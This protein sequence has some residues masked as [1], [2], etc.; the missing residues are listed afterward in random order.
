L[1]IVSVPVLGDLAVEVL[2]GWD[3]GG[4]HRWSVG[5]GFLI[6]DALVLTAAHN[7]GDGEL[8][9]VSCWSV[10][11]M[12]NGLPSS[13]LGVMKILPIWRCWN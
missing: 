3:E 1:S 7:V 9:T 11:A 5:S 8:K 2:H 13:A 6:G 12:R 10:W 4:R